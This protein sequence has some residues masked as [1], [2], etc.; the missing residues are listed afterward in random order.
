[1]TTGMMMEREAALLERELPELP[2]QMPQVF[3]HSAR[4]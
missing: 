2:G 3:S 4:A 1:M